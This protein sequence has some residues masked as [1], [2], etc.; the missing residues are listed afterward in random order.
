[1]FS[2]PRT[3]NCALRRVVCYLGTVI[4]GEPT[5]TYLQCTVVMFVR[6][7]RTRC[8]WN[9]PQV[10]YAAP[11]ILP[12]RRITSRP[13]NRIVPSRLFLDSLPQLQVWVSDGLVYEDHCVGDRLRAQASLCDLYGGR[14]GSGTGSSS[15]SSFPCPLH[16]CSSFIWKIVCSQ[17][18]LCHMRCI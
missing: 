7:L 9:S 6:L 12:P 11:F 8:C 17:T 13:V 1:M 15:T 5:I 10:Q 18:Q 4:K 3:A 14:Y 16:Q 2:R